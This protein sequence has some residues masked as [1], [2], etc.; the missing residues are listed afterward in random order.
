[1]LIL[2]VVDYPWAQVQL[3]TI[4]CILV[5]LA[6]D[7]SLPYHLPIDRDIEYFNEAS[8]LICT[9]HLY[10]FTDFVDDANTRYQI[11]YSLI[12]FTCFNVLVNLS[13]LIY[14][15]SLCFMRT[16]KSYR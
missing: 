15:T 9:Y 13:L 10:L 8:I 1:M 14:V 11:G 16:F 12:T 2:F 6:F 4:K 7:F 5:V 3:M